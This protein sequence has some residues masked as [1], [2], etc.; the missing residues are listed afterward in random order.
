VSGGY[1]YF[2]RMGNEIDE[3]SWETLRMNPRYFMVRETDIETEGVRITTIWSGRTLTERTD[4]YMPVI[5]STTV[6]VD[7]VTQDSYETDSNY[8][9]GGNTRTE[10]EALIMHERA[11]ELAYERAFVDLIDNVIGAEKCTVLEDNPCEEVEL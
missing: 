5:F 1:Y 3:K 11:I 9:S 2:D 10:P 8:L 6:A 7:G 4:T